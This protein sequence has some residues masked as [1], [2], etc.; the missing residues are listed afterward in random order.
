MLS[1]WP[2]LV[3]IAALVLYFF[4]TIN[5]GLA[6]MKY[7]VAAPKMSGNPEFE[8]VLRV[9]MNTLEQLAVFLPALWLFAIFVSPTWGA[10]LGLVWLAGRGL[11]AWSYYQAAEKRTP[12]FAIGTLSASTL[13]LGSLI[14]IILS[15]LQSR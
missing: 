13:L 14:G 4:T 3:T 10:A 12:G 2:S 7:G 9:Q 6:R 5:V 8:R 15:L 1:P 11:Y